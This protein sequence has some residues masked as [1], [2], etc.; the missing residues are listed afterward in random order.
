M[1]LWNYANVFAAAGFAGNSFDIAVGHNVSY[2]STAGDLVFDD[3]TKTLTLTAGTWPTWIREV[4][5]V[6]STNS[7]TNPGPFTVVSVDVTNKIL[8]VLEAV[9]DETPVGTTVVDGSADTRLIDVLL[10]VGG[11][12]LESNAPH[13]L[14]STGA[15]GAS[16]TLDISALEAENALEGGEDLPGRFFYL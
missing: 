4:G 10:S 2:T 16:R 15:L 7:A 1:S 14:V 11:A 13:A 9:T 6:F 3:T 8:T 5:K 12:A